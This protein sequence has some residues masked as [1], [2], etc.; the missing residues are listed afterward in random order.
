MYISGLPYHLVQRGNN[1]EACFF[2]PEDYQFY[3]F[4]LEEVLPK[5]GVHLHKN[6]GHPNIE[7]YLPSD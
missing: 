6:K 4:L 5:Y 2:E 7:I 3:I 1:R